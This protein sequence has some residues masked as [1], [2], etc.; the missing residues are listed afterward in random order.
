M[1]GPTDAGIQPD[2]RPDQ[3]CIRLDETIANQT[4]S[5]LVTDSSTKVNCRN[6]FSL[7]RM[8]LFLLLA[9][10]AL[11]LHI[12][13]WLRVERSASGGMRRLYARQKRGDAIDASAESRLLQELRPK[14]RA[15]MRIASPYR[16]NVLEKRDL[17]N[18]FPD[19]LFRGPHNHRSGWND[20]L[21]GPG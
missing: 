5:H 10:G 11:V 12:A 16:V 19:D 7:S 14:F 21:H 9:I 4:R 17:R 1:V 18:P 20:G 6:Y 13:Q 8:P 2:M 3:D 15:S